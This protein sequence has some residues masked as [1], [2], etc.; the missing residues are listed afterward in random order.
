MQR[1]YNLLQIKHHITHMVNKCN[2]SK[3]CVAQD[4]FYAYICAFS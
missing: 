1:K 2:V 3:I 4:C